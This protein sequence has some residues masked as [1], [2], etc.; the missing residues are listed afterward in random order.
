[1]AK[2]MTASCRYQGRFPNSKTNCEFTIKTD[3]LAASI[4][5][6][7]MVAA[8]RRTMADHYPDKA[9]RPELKKLTITLNFPL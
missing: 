7:P 1:M 8:F 9:G 3:V 2:K 5:A 6:A 4:M